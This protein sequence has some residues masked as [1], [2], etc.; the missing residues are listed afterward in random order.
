MRDNHLP[1]D[2]LDFSRNQVLIVDEDAEIVELI[3]GI[4][5]FELNNPLSVIA[6]RTQLLAQAEDDGQKRHI[7]EVIQ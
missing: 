2:D 3:G 6:G 4:L 5:A 1:P 7:L